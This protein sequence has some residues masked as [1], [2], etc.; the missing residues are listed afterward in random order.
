MLG[1]DI[2]FAYYY[3]LDFFTTQMT[4]P[5]VVWY[6]LRPFKLFV[7]VKRKKKKRTRTTNADKDDN[8]H[9]S[10][11]R[12]YRTFERTS[13]TNRK[14]MIKSDNWNP[15]GDKERRK[16]NF[17]T[18][19]R[20]CCFLTSC[21]CDKIKGKSFLHGKKNKYDKYVCE[22]KVKQ[23]EGSNTTY[24][25]DDS[26]T[27]ECVS[28]P[29]VFKALH[30]VLKKNAHNHDTPLRDGQSLKDSKRRR[31]YGDSLSRSKFVTDSWYFENAYL[32]ASA[33]I[34]MEFIDFFGPSILFVTLPLFFV[35]ATFVLV[36]IL[37]DRLVHERHLAA[38]SEC[39]YKDHGR[40]NARYSDAYVFGY[41]TYNSL[42]LSL[43]GRKYIVSK[44]LHDAMSS[45]S[46]TISMAGELPFEP[47]RKKGW[48][49]KMTP[50]HS[51]IIVGSLIGI[52]G[53]NLFEIQ[54]HINPN[55]YGVLHS[56]W[57]LCMSL[58]FYLLFFNGK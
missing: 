22:K 23:I 11:Y 1:F 4:I 57:H 46:E 43:F 15:K 55:H 10:D 34:L 45:S 17:K 25:F 36:V 13:G 3:K 53:L 31:S 56:W 21:F 40:V 47:K 49:K 39:D 24:I 7:L 38:L 28:M 14:T 19:C 35:H 51:Q 27:F 54:N 2:P 41:D 48:C 32:V 50:N 9:V 33:I 20:G 30:G 16:K 52:I 42:R 5:V 44:R 18:P 29:T 8:N 26:L 58:C 37:T 6:I 12:E